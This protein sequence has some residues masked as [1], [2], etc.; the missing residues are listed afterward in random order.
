MSASTM[1]TATTADDNRWSRPFALGMAN[2]DIPSDPTGF[3]VGLAKSWRARGLACVAV[4]FARPAAEVGVEL[5][6]EVR[7]MLSDEGIHVSE[8]AGV[9]AN[10]VHPDAAVREQAVERVRAAV[11]PASALGAACINSGPGSCSES[12]RESFYRPDA[13]NFT[14]EAEDRAVDTLTRIARV[15]EDT[16]LV[17]A[18]EC[19]QLTTMRSATIIRRVLDRVDHPRIRANFDPINLLDSAYVAF[20]NAERIPEFVDTVGPRYA[21][22]CHV[23]DVIVTDEMPF[24][25]HEAPPGQGLVRIETIFAAAQRLPGDQPVDLIVEHLDPKNAEAS[26]E[27]VRQRAVEVGITLV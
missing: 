19:H 17:Y 18:V 8:F 27:L 6:R 23:K 11:G 14:P 12:W 2:G 1:T 21:H 4:G 22:T 24:E 20:T 7:A 10:L 9:N 5:M 15:I 16:D 26:V 3:S 13:G 25:S